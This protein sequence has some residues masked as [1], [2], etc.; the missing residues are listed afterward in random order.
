MRSNDIILGLPYDVFIFTMLQEMMANKLSIELGKYHHL[1]GS[2]HLYEQHLN[3]SSEILDTP[4]EDS[5]EMPKMGSLE[6]IPGFIEDEKRIR[7][8]AQ[9]ESKLSPYW[10]EL[11]RVLSLY[12]SKKIVKTEPDTLRYWPIISHL[13]Q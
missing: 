8:D 3:L 2:L 6:E 12:N 10:E 11:R 5:F 9:P 1:T 4:L 13:F 7:R